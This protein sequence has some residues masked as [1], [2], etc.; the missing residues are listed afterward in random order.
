MREAAWHATATETADILG[1]L[2][3][4]RSVSLNAD[5]FHTV[6]KKVVLVRQC[7]A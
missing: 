7:T 5:G 2:E 4:L 6:E 3:L 1:A